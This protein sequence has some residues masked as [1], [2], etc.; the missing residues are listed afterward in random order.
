MLHLVLYEK[1]TRFISHFLIPPPPICTF[2]S[3]SKI[4]H[5]IRLYFRLLPTKKFQLDRTKQKRRFAL[6]YLFSMLRIF[7]SNLLLPTRQQ[8]KH[9]NLC[10]YWHLAIISHGFFVFKGED[11]TSTIKQKRKLMSMRNFIEPLQFHSLFR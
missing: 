7:S 1:F 3:I 9:Y 8:C 5:G 6:F 4:G 2:F 10:R 11:S